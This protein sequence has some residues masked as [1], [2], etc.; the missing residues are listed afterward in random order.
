MTT[1]IP[2]TTPDPNQSQLG[3]QIGTV[4]VTRIDASSHDKLSKDFFLYNLRALV[5]S[6]E[7]CPVD[8][9]DELPDEIIEILDEELRKLTVLSTR[10]LAAKAGIDGSDLADLDDLDDDDD[11]EV[12]LTTGGT[13]PQLWIGNTGIDTTDAWDGSV[14]ETDDD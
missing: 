3:P 13:T 2:S 4:E 5:K 6:I 7:N 9:L 12:A 10:F 14:V 1:P 8:G 11:G